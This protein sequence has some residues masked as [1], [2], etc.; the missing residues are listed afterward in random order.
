MAV[1]VTGGAGYIGSHTVLELLKRNE[2]VIVADNLSK[3]HKGSVVGG[4][5]YQGDLRDIDFLDTIFNE[6]EIESVI[7][8][9]AFS[10]VGESV[11]VPLKYYENNL[12]SGLNLLKKMQEYGTK[13]IIFSS[14]AAVYGEP[15]NIPIL[16]KDS[17]VPTNPYGEAKL[18]FEKMLK[19]TDNAHGIKY[20]SLRYFNACG[21]DESG[22]IGED[23]DPE[24]HL[25]PIVLQT[26]L[27][28][29]KKITVYG[30]DYDTED[31]T[32]IRDYIHVTDLSNAHILA[33]D[34]LRRTQESG[35]Y[36]LGSG[37]GYSVMEILDKSMEVTDMDIPWEYGPRRAGDPSILIA[38][39]D[40]IKRELGWNPVYDDIGKIIQSAWNWHKNHPQGF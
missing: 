22:M 39:S 6:N 3:G 33:L 1:L 7:H 37:R 34:K 14:T 2:R 31:G 26:A 17:T 24:T 5:F 20:V 29:R 16:E 27:K 9:A 19:W 35:I 10:L 25:I 36:N 13:K 8:F 38:S 21:A 4:R 40:K 11:G 32:C 30:N 12:I 18:A 23:H 15:Q 28:Q